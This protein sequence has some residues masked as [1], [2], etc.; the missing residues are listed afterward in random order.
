[1]SQP[2]KVQKQLPEKHGMLKKKGRLWKRLVIR[3]YKIGWQDRH[4]VLIYSADESLNASNCKTLSL[5]H[6]FCKKDETFDIV[7]DK[8]FCLSLDVDGAKKLLFAPTELERDEWIDVIRKY[9]TQS[10]ITNTYEF[11]RDKNSKLGEGS[12]GTVYKGRE[13]ATGKIWAL[14]E[15]PKASVQ[16]DDLQNLKEE[17]RISTLVGSHPNI[18]YMK[19]FVE[20]SDRY[21]IVLEFL[22]GGELFDR[23]VESPQ[24]HFTEKVAA[25]IMRQIMGALGYLHGRGIAHRDLKPENFLMATPDPDAAVKIADFGFAC[26]VTGD[27]SASGLCGSPGYVAPE[28]LTSTNGYGLAVDIWSMGVI[29]YILL[30]GIP[31]FAAESD[32]ESFRLTTAGKYDK[33]HLEE[34]SP[35]ARELVAKMLTYNPLKRITAEAALEHGWLAGR[36]A[37]DRALKS[38]ENLRSWRARMRLKKAIIATVATTKIKAIM[39]KVAEAA[40]SMQPPVEEA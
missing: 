35:S 31:P 9:S 12:F 22:T 23:I 7:A 8:M 38:K 25:S 29:L 4:G 17:V 28:I 26:T 16:G 13:K 6:S 39:K 37:A 32:E 1:M 20:N 19:E 27:K 30:T 5:E 15:I 21:Y 24:G 36:D 33:S 2:F 10:L 40:S 11:S 18:V 3:H 14:K 34:V